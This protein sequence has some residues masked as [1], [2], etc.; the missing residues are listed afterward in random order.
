MYSH[1][2]RPK[3][4]DFSEARSKDEREK[5]SP[6]EMKTF[7]IEEG[8]E[9]RANL[10]RPRT[11]KT[12]EPFWPMMIPSALGNGTE[13]VLKREGTLIHVRSQNQARRFKLRAGC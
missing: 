9:V 1:F 2:C 11:D 8:L 12:N 4:E 13:S 3:D 5:S 6:Y 10:H 7:K